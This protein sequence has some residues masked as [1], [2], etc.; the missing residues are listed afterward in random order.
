VVQATLVAKLSPAQGRELEARLGRAAFDFRGVPYARFSARGEGVVVTLY[1]SGKLVVQGADAESFWLRHLPAGPPAEGQKAP[2][3]AS[4]GA[5]GASAGSASGEPGAGSS[6]PTVGSDETGKGDLFGPL[7]VVALRL[8]PGEGQRLK[9]SGV[10]DSK[11]IADARARELGAA[12][13]ARYRPGIVRLDPA[14]YNVA[15]ARSGNLNVLLAEC[16]VR[17]IEQVAQA[18]D[19]V[20]V[21]QF[22]PAGRLERGL[23]GRGL[24]LEQRPRAEL[25]EPAVAAASVVA[26]A[27]FLEALDEL[28]ERFAVTLRKGAGAPVDQAAREFLRLHGR[29]QLGQVAKLHFKNVERLPGA[30]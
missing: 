12:L 4:E 28:S 30:R 26:R 8:E 3:S 22:G 27:L 1:T 10:T 7:V 18:G 16:H 14:D 13:E 9:S 29:E 11:L 17:A 5:T 20:V 19:R 25:Y 24:A 23:A 2:A 6:L 21:D 15:Y